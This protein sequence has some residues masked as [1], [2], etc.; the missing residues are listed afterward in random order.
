MARRL[1]RRNQNN[2]REEIKHQFDAR[3]CGMNGR[4]LTH[5]HTPGW[6]GRA[7]G[8][9]LTALLAGVLEALSLRQP[10]SLSLLLML[11]VAYS[12]L[13][14]GLAPAIVSGMIS[15]GYQ[16][17]AYQ[18]PGS[19][20][21]YTPENLDRLMIFALA[22]P[23][24]ITVLGS[25]RRRLD[26]LLVRERSLR[27]QAETER[28]RA[29]DII[30]SITD[31]FFHLDTQ[32][33][34]VYVNQQAEQLVGR[35]RQ[36]LRGT[37]V[38]DAFPPLVGSTWDREYHRAIREKVA[39][40]FEE[41]YPP[42][43]TWFETHAYPSE[44]GLTIYLRSINERKRVEEG[45]A[46][47]ARQQAAVAALGQKALVGGDI[48][49][50]LEE[51][52]Q[53]LAS[54]LDVELTKILELLPDGQALAIRA[55]VGW[56]DTAKY[57][58]SASPQSQAGYTM[59]TGQPVIVED[60]G[61]ETRFKGAPILL[62]HG[63]VSGVSVIV[64]GSAKPFGILGAF[65]RSRRAFTADDIHF[66]QAVANLVAAAI[67][68]QRSGAALA[69]SEQRFRQLAENV[70][71]VFYIVGLH[72]TQLLY[73]NPAFE[74]VWG[75]AS[76]TLFA[77]PDSW[78]EAIHPDDQPEVRK[79]LAE[80]D[81]GFFDGEYRVVRPDGTIRWIHDRS[82]PVLDDRGHPYRIV[83]AA[84][85]IT[86][87][88][89]AAEAARHLAASQ[90]SI[91]ARDAVLAEVAHDLRNPLNTISMAAMLLETTELPAEKRALHARTIRRAVGGAVRLIQDL[92][93]VTRIET[94]QLSI[95]RKA[96]DVASLVSEVCDA[97][98]ENANEKSITLDRVVDDDVS[99]VSGDRDRIL[100][101]L[102][103]LLGNALKFTPKGGRVHVRARRCPD[104]IEF[105]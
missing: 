14:G 15:V 103:N 27:R 38:W 16:L 80:R 72:P 61:A 89:D 12:V 37:V 96:I 20:F 67:E 1:L 101:A 91:Q 52:V 50:L 58:I 66:M 87:L 86:E 56:T 63:V 49:P 34:Y 17:W 92:L 42:L 23:L 41:F 24:V 9:V 81:D 68:R 59:A 39:V 74:S 4:R 55:G 6:V 11:A 94:G 33:R 30:E 75:R 62:D 77:Q 47:R 21:H 64:P 95:D 22:T 36:E 83:G 90:A 105:S 8:P 102:G 5:L 60:L 31:G 10:P 104:G 85:D 40:H 53:T 19:N 69:E 93:D 18:T 65:S 98:Q 35:T 100:Q 54:T 7:S 88:R 57:R 25:V 28:R 84:E 48:G 73:I 45:L 29:V 99:P 3:A 13:S 32:W 97:F 43:N 26:D 70:R 46:A 76:E 79:R 2:H 44:E 71:E 78:L 82:S 51:A